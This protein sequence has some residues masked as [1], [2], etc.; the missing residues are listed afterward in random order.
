MGQIEIKRV[1]DK[2]G[3]DTFTLFSCIMI[4]IVEINLMRPTCTE[5]K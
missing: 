1:T 3:L 2:R 5:M 4:C